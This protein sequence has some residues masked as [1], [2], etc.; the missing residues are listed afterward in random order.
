MVIAN[1]EQGETSKKVRGI[2]QWD[3]GQVLRI[4]GL[5]L[6]TAVEIH[7]S[8][9]EN[10]GDCVTRIGVT[11]DG[12]TDVVIPDSM[13]E[14]EGAIGQEYYIYAWVYLTD[15]T[16][17][18]TEYEIKLSVETRSKPEAFDKPE[19]AELFREA[20]K[21]VNE[22]AERA[23]EAG[24]NAESARDEAQE[25]ADGIRTDVQGLV[26]QATQAKNTAIEN[27]NMSTNNAEETEAD[28][29]E[30][31]NSKNI[32]GVYM[33]QAIEASNKSEE[34][35][36]Q[37]LNTLS[38]QPKRYYRLSVAE[39]EAIENPHEGD[40]CYV[41]D[42]QNSRTAIYFYDADDIDGDNVNPEWQ[43]L[44]NAEF[45]Q[46]DRVTLL[47]I[48]NLATVALTGSYNDLLD[49]PNR[50]NS[51]IVLDGTAD[52]ITWDYNQS[53]TA[54]VTLTEDKAISISNPYNGCIACIQCYGAQLD[55]SDET[56]YRKSATFDYIEPLEAEHIMYTLIYNAGK[57]DVTAM[58]YAG[59]EASA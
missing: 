47:K 12:V 26:E 54:V 52:I 22:C 7:F 33:Q 25:T 10:R 5:H 15:E 1:F 31:E 41:V 56:L 3:Y 36:N 2:R 43:F 48:L 45:A 39:M 28:R 18:H 55:F 8:L 44:G 11:R 6:P 20:I 49:I 21:A 46:M 29:V 53:D 4:Q 9:Q 27:A 51:P 40:Q 19:D 58:V 34:A 17:G 37:F 35:L 13:V 42:L 30:T 57:W 14:N 38:A 32:A 23:E 24:K 59:G 16:S 50:Y